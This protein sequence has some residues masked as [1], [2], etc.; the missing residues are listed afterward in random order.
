MEYELGKMLKNKYPDVPWIEIENHNNI[1]QLRSNSN[2]EFIKMKRY[3]IVG[4]R[5]THKYV[6]NQ[7]VSDFLV[8]YTSSGCNAMCLYCVFGK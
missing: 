1:E 4:I 7:K 8:P 2:K 5:K 3:L 6:P